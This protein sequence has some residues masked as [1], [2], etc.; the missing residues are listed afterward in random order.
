MKRKLFYAAMAAVVM[1]VA[2]PVSAEPLRVAQA[3]A[4]ILP[5]HEIL[6]IIRSTGLD[7]IE[8]PVRR[9]ATYVLRAVE[10]GGEE[11]RVVVDA[12]H[13]DI[14]S[15]TPTVSASRAVRPGLRMGPYEPMA[16]EGYLGPEA[17]PPPGIYGAGPPVVY[18]NERPVI[19]GP[20][21][22]APIPN[23]QP[24]A[25]SAAPPVASAPLPPPDTGPPLEEPHVIMEPDSGEHGN[26]ILPPPPERFPQRVAPP[27]N[28]KPQPAAKPAPKRAAAVTPPPLPKPRPAS[29]ASQ[30]APAVDAAPIPESKPADGGLR[31]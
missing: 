11:V 16:P 14:L 7:P 10:A 3:N 5:A 15:V 4:E 18:E 6:T 22:M 2:L 8:R 19:Y 24:R 29:A 30:P 31:H 9:G 13:G 1:T 20:R 17:L 26:S 25:R 23:V 27:A 12:R 28:V 21:P